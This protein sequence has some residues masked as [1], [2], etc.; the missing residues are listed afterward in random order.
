MDSDCPGHHAPTGNRLL[1]G[2][3]YSLDE[4]KIR[5]SSRQL[6]SFF[7]WAKA[8]A[9][10]NRPAVRNLGLRTEQ[11]GNGTPGTFQT[12]QLYLAEIPPS[13]SGDVVEARVV[14]RDSNGEDL[15]EN[16]QGQ[17]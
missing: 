1:V 14:V 17:A 5:E 9:A 7:S 2:V 6:N 13:Y 4:S 3:K 8:R 12:T 16:Q 11:I 15:G 10:L